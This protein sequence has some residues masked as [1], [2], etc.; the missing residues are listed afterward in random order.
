MKKTHPYDHGRC[1]AA[2]T[3][4]GA[5]RAPSRRV[6]RR[7]SRARP[8]SRCSPLRRERHRRQRH[9]RDTVDG[10]VTLHGK[11]RTEAR[12]RRRAT[13]SPRS[14]AR[15]EVKNLLQVV[16]AKNEEKVR[17]VRRPD[18]AQVNDAFKKDR[19]PRVERDQRAV[20][21]QGCRAARRRNAVDDDASAG[22]HDRR[23]R[24]GR[25]S[26]RDRGQGRR[27]DRGRRGRTEHQGSRR[28]RVRQGDG[29]DERRVDHVGDQA[30]A[31][32]PTARRRRSTST[33]T[34]LNGQVTL[35]G[36][37]PTAAAKATAEA[38][39]RKVER[40]EGR[41]QRSAG[42]GGAEA[43]CGRGQGRDIET[44]SR[45]RSSAGMATT[46]DDV[47]VEVK[48]GVVRLTGSVPD[49]GGARHGGDHGA[50]DSRA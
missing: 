32:S 28:D 33:S 31:C 29:R 19:A 10:R 27:A 8:R 26:R 14:T 44:P 2:F 1:V 23:G 40:R 6:R 37:V 21:Q 39:A 35:F 43:G 11:V 13:S 38:E 46:G 49:R 12:R 18:H 48:A 47:D 45:R 17:G 24:A 15:R 4:A 41:Q 22:H 3:F 36:M 20:G 30:A 7:G 34:R 50:C 25:A 9:Q 16:P 42:R 5:R